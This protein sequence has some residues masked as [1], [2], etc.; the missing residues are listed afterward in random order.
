MFLRAGP[1]PRSFRV[2][3]GPARGPVRR[4]RSAGLAL[5]RLR[6]DV[7]R[8]ARQG[9]GLANTRSRMPGNDR[10]PG[11]GSASD[12]LGVFQAVRVPGPPSTSAAHVRDRRSR[13]A[14]SESGKLRVTY[15]DRDFKLRRPGRPGAASESERATP[16]TPRRRRPGDSESD[17]PILRVLTDSEPESRLTSSE[18]AAGPPGVRRGPTTVRW[19]GALSWPGRILTGRLSH[20]Q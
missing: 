15:R 6:L 20:W 1:I 5:T 17:V 3:M 19:D 11:P 9:E 10:E 4:T 7:S 12:S 16:A 2:C 13:T 8:R 14:D 18:S